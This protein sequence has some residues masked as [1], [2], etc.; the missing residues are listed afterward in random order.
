MNS[1]YGKKIGP[2]NTAVCL[3]VIVHGSENTFEQDSISQ[4]CPLLKAK[5]KNE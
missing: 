3:G 4:L 5:K 1:K 2:L